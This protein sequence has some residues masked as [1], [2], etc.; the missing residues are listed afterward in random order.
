MQ[1]LGDMGFK[2]LKAAAEG[3]DSWARVEHDEPST[4]DQEPT[5]EG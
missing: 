3:Y 5:G 1:K 2:A 4:A